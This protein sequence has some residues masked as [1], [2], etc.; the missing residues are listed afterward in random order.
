V[1]DR[2]ASTSTEGSSFLAATLSVGEG[3][4]KWDER[5]G[6]RG[7]GGGDWCPAMWRW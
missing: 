6:G 3:D 7:G 4:G 1:L 5:V 2:Q